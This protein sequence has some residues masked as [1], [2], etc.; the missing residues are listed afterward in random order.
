MALRNKEKEK[1]RQL[2]EILEEDY[3]EL[4][5][6]QLQF[7]RNRVRERFETEGKVTNEVLFNAYLSFKRRLITALETLTFCSHPMKC[8]FGPFGGKKLRYPRISIPTFEGL[9]GVKT[10]TFTVDEYITLPVLTVS[11]LEDETEVVC[12]AP[13]GNFCKISSKTFLF[14]I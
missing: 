13:D 2:L 4:T 6:G 8:D 5:P 3:E 7:L 9:E 14:E 11:Y 10:G 12:I 1:Q